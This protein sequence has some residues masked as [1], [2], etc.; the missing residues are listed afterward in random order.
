MLKS[1]KRIKV[2]ALITAVFTIFACGGG[3]ALDEALAQDYPW[4]TFFG[5]NYFNEDTTK[6]VRIYEVNNG[7]GELLPALVNG[8]PAPSRF[9]QEDVTFDSR[10]D[11]KTYTFRV[12]DAQGLVLVTKEMRKSGRDAELN[13][14][15]T[16]R[17]IN[18]DIS[19]NDFPL[20]RAYTL[21]FSNNDPNQP[22]HLWVQ[23]ETIGPN[24][25]VEPLGTAS[26]LSPFNVWNSATTT[27][28]LVFQ[29]GRNGNVIATRNLVMTGAEANVTRSISVA[30]VNGNLQVTR[31]TN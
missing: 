17:Y 25:R 27:K 3:D 23:P 13:K 31:H 20:R 29:A 28:T 26:R 5:F 18:G 14:T 1:S 2:I 8:Q 9:E 22:V 7:K 10:E 21:N 6:G 15:I 11:V 30:W 16:I 19:F 24:N 12:E 4:T